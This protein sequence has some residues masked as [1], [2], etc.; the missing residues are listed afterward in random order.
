MNK[1]S[2]E[3]RD[4]PRSGKDASR[5]EVLHTVRGTV[6]LAL[7]TS[8]LCSGSVWQGLLVAARIREVTQ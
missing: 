5:E 3:A 7:V 2:S 4:R 1:V 8:G 6:A